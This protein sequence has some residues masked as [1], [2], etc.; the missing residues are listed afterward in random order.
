M[1]TST[2][3]IG[4]HLWRG[5][6]C[7]V[8]LYLLLPASDPPHPWAS[9]ARILLNRASL[10]S[11]ETLHAVRHAYLRR[12]PVVYEVDPALELPERGTDEREVWDVPPDADFVAEATWRLARANAVDARDVTN[13]TWPLRV[14]ALAAGATAAPG[15]DID[16]VSP[17]RQAGLV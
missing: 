12:E 3:R 16:V 2:V 7:S 4:G 13:P 11:P 15:W 14:M 9:S 8:G 10:A 5:R 1:P 17:R 6:K